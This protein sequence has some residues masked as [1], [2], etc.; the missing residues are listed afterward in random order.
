M[1]FH[2]KSD[3]CSQTNNLP[4]DLQTVDCLIR[5]RL[6]GSQ[7]PQGE[8][9]SSLNGRQTLVDN[10]QLS[11]HKRVYSAPAVS[12]ERASRAN[13]CPTPTGNATF[14]TAGHF[15]LRQEP[16]SISMALEGAGD[17]DL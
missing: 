15:C 10:S 12:R 3:E 5:T 6:P 11:L 17:A 4:A 1:G 16:P 8:P 2:Q 13:R 7:G 9:H 14:E